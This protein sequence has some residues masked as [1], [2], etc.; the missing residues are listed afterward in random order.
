MSFEDGLLQPP[1]LLRRLRPDEAPVAGDLRA[2]DPPAVWVH[3]DDV[4]PEFWRVR[5]GEHVLAPLDVA[6][7]ADGH[8]VLLPHCPT[9]L[10]AVLAG[11]RR[12]LSPGAIVTAAVSMIRGAA[13]ARR[14]EI[15]TGRWWVDAD[16][17]PLLAPG[18]DPW[19]AETG[20]LLGELAESASGPLRAAVLDAAALV[21]EP[22][23]AQ[24][25]QDRVEDAL[26]EAAE[27][28]P[29]RWTTGESVDREPAPRRVTS[30]RQTMVDADDGAVDARAPVWATRLI[31]RDVV[32]RAH[33]ALARVST[34]ASRLAGALRR[35]GSTRGQGGS[36]D[37]DLG[38]GAGDG[39]HAPRR[40]RRR[41]P[42]VVAA[43]VGIAVTVGGLVWPDD[44]DSD[45]VEPPSGAGQA[46]EMPVGQTTDPAGR[47]EER[48]SVDGVLEAL[49]TCS[50][51]DRTRCDAVREDPTAPPPTGVV[52]DDAAA[53]DVALLDEYGG[54]FVYRVAAEG[55]TPQVLVIVDDNGEWLVR[56][57]YDS[58]DQP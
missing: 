21:S 1:P 41:A 33:G 36:A 12:S 43:A 39:T 20:A 11:S 52:T 31:D 27:P 9:H 51:D 2:G 10:D 26:F 3:A 35:H 6:R 57:V 53:R 28:A 8:D 49:S 42:L 46:T 16:G 18:C 5:D 38:R 30:L 23:P 17:R 44:T 22:R 50:S 40:R 13:E 47:P 15:T 58:A 55:H 14:C 45:A 7:A 24:H 54:V 25:R 37:A 34:T 29:L 56:D 32:V 48:D 4:P 19:P